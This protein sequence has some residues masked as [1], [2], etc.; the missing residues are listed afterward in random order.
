MTGSS[1]ESGEEKEDVH[2]AGGQV[3]WQTE[4]RYAARFQEA[5]QS[6]LRPFIQ[7]Q[8]KPLPSG[9]C[10]NHGSPCESNV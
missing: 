4:L 8:Y 1:D 2:R 6:K 3:G 5:W 7:Q 10:N 9:S